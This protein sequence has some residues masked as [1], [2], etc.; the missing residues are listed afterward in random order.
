MFL[1]DRDIDKIAKRLADHLRVVIQEG[2]TA[3]VDAVADLTAGVTD[4]L[5]EIDTIVTQLETDIAALA[6]IPPDNTAAI[7]AQVA[8]LTTGVA[9]A[10][11]AL[12]PATAAVAAVAGAS[13]V[14]GASGAS[15]VD[16]GAS[17]ASGASGAA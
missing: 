9:A 7:E 6:N 13:G 2:N 17:G 14:P 8:K 3:M 11:T 15:G 10:R 1:H 16:A 12:A 5:A 4:A